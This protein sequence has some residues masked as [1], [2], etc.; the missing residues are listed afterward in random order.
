MNTSELIKKFNKGSLHLKDAEI[1]D[2]Y[3][4]LELIE[5]TLIGQGEMFYPTR[6]FTSNIKNTVKVACKERGLL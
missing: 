3:R 5:D 1:M 4:E 6:M 2:L